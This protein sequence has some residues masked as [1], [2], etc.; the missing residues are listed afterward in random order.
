MNNITIFM[1]LV[2][3]VLIFTLPRRYVLIPILI[4]GIILPMSE[5]ILIAELDFTAI[6]ILLVCGWLRLIIRSE[7]H[8]VI[9]MNIIDKTMILYVFWTVL[10]YVLMWQTFGSL[11]YKLG[12]ASYFLGIYF[13]VRFYSNNL[14]D[15]ERMIRVLLYLSIFIAIFV[16]IERSTQNNYFSFLGGVPYTTI[17]R[18]GKLRCFGPF[19]HPI[20]L[21]S[22]G[23]FLFQL[24]FYMIWKEKGRKILGLISLISSIVIVY[25]SSSSGPAFSLMASMLG[26]FMWHFRK[27]MRGI[28]WGTIICLIGLH[29]VMK[30]PVWALINRISVFSSSSH[31]HRFLLIDN[32][33][34]RFNEWW[35]IGVKDTAHWNEWIQTWDVSNNYVRVGVDGGVLAFVLFILI[36][37]FSFRH[38]GKIMRLSKDNIN[39]QKLFWTLGVAMFSYVVS[40]LGVSLWDQTIVI[41][42][43]IIALIA[44]LQYKSTK[45]PDPAKE[46]IPAAI[47]NG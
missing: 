38:I 32:F 28:V 30:G 4:F 17:V 29:L 19:S 27:H 13:L 34:T 10:S 44:S 2:G 46:A 45:L 41:W 5:R 11:I 40:F 36:I 6:R 8:S 15:V 16:A 12:G 3:A 20:T 22:F 35:L 18:E 37:V 31:Y 43:V 21:G 24:A 39:H 23:A 33:I 25:S 42:Y 14:D 1:L 26:L 47:Y 7:Y 9:K